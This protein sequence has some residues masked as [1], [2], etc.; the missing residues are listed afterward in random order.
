MARA[1]WIQ[2][3]AVLVLASLCGAASAAWAQRNG[4]VRNGQDNEPTK[5]E[6]RSR[7]RAAGVTPPPAELRR[8]TGT[9]ESL[10]R[11]LM[12]EERADDMTT[13]PADPN[14][15]MALAPSPQTPP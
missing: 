1:G 13:A 15:S 5:A 3:A 2:P 8:E 4:D 7:E 11:T 6:V 10:Y 9:V 12:S 14:A